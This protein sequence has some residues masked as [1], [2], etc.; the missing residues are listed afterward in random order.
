MKSL[1]ISFLMLLSFS[2]LTFAQWNI[3]TVDNSNDVGKW[4][5]IAYDSHGYPHIVYFDDTNNDLMYTHWTGDAWKF[6]EIHDNMGDYG[7]AIA[8]DEQDYVHIVFTYSNYIYYYTNTSGSFERISFQSGS[9]S[10]GQYPDICLYYN[11]STGQTTPHISWYYYSPKDL[12]HAYLDHNTNRLISEAVDQAS[13]VGINSH[14]TCDSNENLYI[15]YYDQGA[16]ALKFAHYD[17]TKW[18]AL[19]IDDNGDVGLYNSI[20]LDNNTKPC[21]SYYDATNGNL[22]YVIIENVNSKE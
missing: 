19:T 11:Q 5:D 16:G 2:T 20:A 7:C 21:I 22:K 18:S 8:I 1:L 10:R 13:D 4:S 15:S 6:E 9:N 3:Q 14:I 12:Y 17:G